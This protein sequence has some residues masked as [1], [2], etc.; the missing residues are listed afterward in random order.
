MFL[1]VSIPWLNTLHHWAVWWWL[2]ALF[3]TINTL[4]LKY[5]QFTSF[6]HDSMTG[7][8]AHFR[9]IRN[10]YILYRDFLMV[11]SLLAWAQIFFKCISSSISNSAFSFGSL[12]Y[13]CVFG[14]A[15]GRPS[16]SS[17]NITI[18]KYIWLKV[19]ELLLK[20]HFCLLLCNLSH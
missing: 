6:L 14:T 15:W 8:R 16:G 13:F 12:S 18:E 20:C 19:P 3:C 7:S 4:T 5:L 9:F 2:Q 17:W 1:P 11:L 10:V